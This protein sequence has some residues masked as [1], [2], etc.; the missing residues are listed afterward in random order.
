M[1]S[2]VAPGFT[3][4]ASEDGGDAVAVTGVS[5]DKTSLSLTVGE[6]FRLN[7][8]VSPEN[9]DNRAVGWSSDNSM[10]ASV[11]SFGLVKAEHEGTAIITA[12]T[13]DGYF[14]AS[15]TVTVDQPAE[16][17]STASAISA[18]AT[19]AGTEIQPAPPPPAALSR[20]FG[21]SRV[22][23]AIEV[24]KIGWVRAENVVLATGENFPDALAGGPLAYMLD[25]PILL[26]KGAR[27]TLE[28]AVAGRI[29][30]LGA[31]NIYILGGA[32]ALSAEM[33][34]AL[35]KDYNVI[36]LAGDDRY[37]TSVA[38]A[39]KMDEIRGSA[40]QNVFVASGLN[41]PD[42]LSVTPVAAMM[43][44]PIL[45]AD[46]DGLR[47]LTVDYI[48][49]AKPVDA[50]IVGG[51]N[52]FAD[53]FR[54]IN[55]ILGQLYSSVTGSAGYIFGADRYETSAAVAEYY[56]YLFGGKTALIATG[57]DF[58]DA[59]AGGAL[60]GKISAPLF[61]INGAGGASAHIK[62]AIAD[63]SPETVYVLGGVN[64]VSDAA[65]N[66]HIG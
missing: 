56:G 16:S 47:G 64:A 46:A 10:I 18:S 1:A 11:G 48:A 15:C 17:D 32:S 27:H 63:L 36:R 26:T 6:T 8:E 3:A 20:V 53:N 23:T 55:I 66:H 24:S 62:S 39:E 52:A 25:A 37:G 59:L 4:D 31:K 49:R 12:T 41:Y 30:E 42:A 38:I 40:P 28:P 29:E 51:L 34:A 58:P 65:V 5:L 61:L 54:T 43:S 19:D 35:E 57:R 14:T 50:K 60:G 7:A 9:A 22:E 2:A 33:E 45:F 44:A 13:H 21:V